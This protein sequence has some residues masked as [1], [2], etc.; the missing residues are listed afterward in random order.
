M[1]LAHCLLQEPVPGRHAPDER[2]GGGG[3]PGLGP[4]TLIGLIGPGPTGAQNPAVPTT[5][6][7]AAICSQKCAGEPWSKRTL[8]PV[9][10]IAT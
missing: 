7:R 4:S 3:Y 10:P 1:P 6:F 9:A 5:D 8:N 2:F